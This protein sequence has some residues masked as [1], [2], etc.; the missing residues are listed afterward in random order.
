MSF[1]SSASKN[2][3]NLVREMSRG[4]SRRRG[5]ASTGRQLSRGFSLRRRAAQASGGTDDS[6][7]ELLRKMTR[8]EMENLIRSKVNEGILT[9]ADLGGTSASKLFDETNETKAASRPGSKLS[10][11]LQLV[12]SADAEK[13]LLSLWKEYDTKGTGAVTLDMYIKA[14]TKHKGGGAADEDEESHLAMS[15]A[16]IDADGDGLIGLED[17][18]EQWMHEQH[19][20][21]IMA[22]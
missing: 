8:K 17:F 12:I 19:G 21:G 16:M 14:V 11:A 18:A 9:L 15:F 5:G 1:A 20:Q 13:E 2:A 22:A 4:L 7:D 3:G 10:P 6:I